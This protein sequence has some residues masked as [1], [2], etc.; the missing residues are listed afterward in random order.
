MIRACVPRAILVTGL[1]FRTITRYGFFGWAIFC[2]QSGF[3]N[4]PFGL[5]ETKS[6]NRS[7]QLI[8]LR[9]EGPSSQMGVNGPGIG[10][11]ECLNEKESTFAF[12]ARC[13]LSST[14][15]QRGDHIAM[16][17]MKLKCHPS[18]GTLWHLFA[19]GILEVA[20][21]RI[22]VIHVA[23][24]IESPTVIIGD[25]SKRRLITN[26]KVAQSGQPPHSEG[27]REKQVHVRGELWELS[28]RMSLVGSL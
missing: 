9:F 16:W 2:F 21:N 18:P 24:K 28:A 13:R 4:L 6:Q 1:R 27:E 5:M 8:K 19:K 12:I 26:S 10:Q 17:T 15:N 14:A 25:I 11:F 3:L 20:G 22:K 7:Q 23:N